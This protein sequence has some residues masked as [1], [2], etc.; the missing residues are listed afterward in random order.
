MDSVMSNSQFIES[1]DLANVSKSKYVIG[2]K[3]LLI[4]GH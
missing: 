3:T 4:V 2:M 1:T